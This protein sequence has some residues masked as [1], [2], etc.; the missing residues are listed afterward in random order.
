MN[1]IV[2]DDDVELSNSDIGKRAYFLYTHESPNAWFTFSST[3][4]NIGI[5]HDR[6]LKNHTE[7]MILS[8]KQPA[9]HPRFG[10][11]TVIKIMSMDCM[12][13]PVNSLVII[14]DK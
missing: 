7:V 13:V 4:E 1:D 8:D 3:I 10:P 6:Q 14:N 11:L 9:H 5:Q 2:L 12:W